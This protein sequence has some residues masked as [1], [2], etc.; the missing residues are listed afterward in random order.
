VEAR[1]VQLAE[2]QKVRVKSGLLM[3]TEGIVIKV[4]NNKAYVLLESLGYELS[5]QFEKGNLEPV[6]GG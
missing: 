6:G 5:A 2:G 1:P 3:D 4:T